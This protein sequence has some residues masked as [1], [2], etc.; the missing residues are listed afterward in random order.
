MQ[1]AP[2]KKFRGFQSPTTTPI[3]DEI[4]DELM[5]DLT[6]AE[7]KVLL[8]ICRRTFGFKKASDTISLNQIAD[9]ITTRDG[10]ILDYGT[11]LSRRHVQRALK[12]LEEKNIIQVERRMDE[13]GINEINTYALNF[14]TGVGT[15]SPYG[16]DKTSGGVGTPVSPTTNS[17][18]QTVNNTV[19]GVV[20]GGER[21]E[22]QKLKDLGEPPEKTAYLAE[23]I[24]R[25]LGDA[26]S[27]RFYELVAAKVPERVIRETLSEIK[28]DGARSPARLFTYRMQRYA[29]GKRKRGVVKGMGG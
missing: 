8:Y 25:A 6:G 24:V 4:F 23:E 7:L 1:N 11:G 16:R 3:P 29:L 17:K 14:L 5:T 13:A 20:K 10:R 28:T 27:V 12:T 15:K 26:K 22:L 19:N 9:G 2:S 18:Q 21:G